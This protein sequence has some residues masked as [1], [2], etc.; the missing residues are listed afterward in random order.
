MKS[1]YYARTQQII[2][3]ITFAKAVKMMSTAVT[4]TFAFF[5]KTT[6]YARKTTL[7]QVSHFPIG[8][9]A[10]GRCSDSLVQASVLYI[11]S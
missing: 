1:E 8:V 4:P 5:F 6:M 10:M 9:G 7:P 2:T 11:R 3:Y